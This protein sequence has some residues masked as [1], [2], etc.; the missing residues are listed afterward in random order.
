MAYRPG[1]RSKETKGAV[2]GGTFASR[3]PFLF[4]VA[5]VAAGLGD[6]AVES[7]SNTGIFGHYVDNNHLGV[8]PTL[9]AGAVVIAEVL[10]LRFVEAWRR[11]T[12]RSGGSLIDIARNF[13]SRSVARDFPVI[14]ALQLLSVFAMESGEQLVAGGKLLGGTA[15]LGGPILFSLIAHA[16]IGGLCTFALGACMRAI[17]R[18]FA[19]LV[20]TAIRFIWL[21]IASAASGPF[22]I[23]RRATFCARAQA[24][25]VRE[26]G[27]RAPPLLHAPA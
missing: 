22:R 26:I 1:F 9:L 19:S 27:G 16:I 11:S 8:V 7:V 23:D 5:F 24:P 4:A 25:H 3:L 14:F 20:Q 10:V 6:P 2:V 18:A 17:V 13:G 15:W 12:N 21:A